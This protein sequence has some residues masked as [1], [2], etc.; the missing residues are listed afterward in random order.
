MRHGKGDQSPVVLGLQ[1]LCL[2]HHYLSLKTAS[3]PLSLQLMW[4]PPQQELAYGVISE[5]PHVEG[6]PPQFESVL[7][8]HMTL[9]TLVEILLSQ[10]HLGRM[11]LKHHVQWLPWGRG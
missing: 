9:P 5:T 6:C 8:K 10:E 2:G 4:V 11:S 1:L 7:P 3:Q